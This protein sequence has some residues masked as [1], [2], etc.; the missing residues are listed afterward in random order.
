MYGSR[1]VVV[2]DLFRG[3]L[4][5]GAGGNSALFTAAKLGVTATQGVF[6]CELIQLGE[7]VLSSRNSWLQGWMPCAFWRDGLL[8]LEISFCYLP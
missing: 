6:F 1:E 4:Q 5:S 7:D 3:R 8:L 2:V